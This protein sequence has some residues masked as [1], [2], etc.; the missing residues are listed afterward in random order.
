MHFIFHQILHFSIFFFF[1]PQISIPR[2]A[3]T[4]SFCS[5]LPFTKLETLNQVHPST[6]VSAKNAGYISTHSCKFT[7]F[8][9]PFCFVW[10]WH[11]LTQVFFFSLSSLL[12]VSEECKT[13]KHTLTQVETDWSTAK[14]QVGSLQGKVGNLESVLRVS[15]LLVYDDADVVYYFLRLVSSYI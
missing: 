4:H 10:L 9:L 1:P 15:L 2:D 12:Q 3:K 5:F 14:V 8:S 13:L 6:A 11:T 7:S